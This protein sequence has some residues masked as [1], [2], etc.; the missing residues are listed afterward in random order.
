MKEFSHENLKALRGN[1]EIRHL[2]PKEDVLKVH[3][4]TINKAFAYPEYGFTH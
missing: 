2:S 3:R 4:I 1:E